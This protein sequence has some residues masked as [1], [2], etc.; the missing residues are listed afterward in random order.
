VKKTLAARYAN[1][2]IRKDVYDIAK[3]AVGV[4]AAKYGL[5]LA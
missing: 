1:R 2:L 5:K 3:V 4:I